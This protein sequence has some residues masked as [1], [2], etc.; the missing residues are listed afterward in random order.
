MGNTIFNHN[1]SAGKIEVILLK[2]SDKER[3]D[4]IDHGSDT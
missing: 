4:R 2:N 3:Y 1:M